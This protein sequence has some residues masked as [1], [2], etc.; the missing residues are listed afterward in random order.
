MFKTGEVFFIMDPSFIMGIL[1]GLGYISTMLVGEC[2]GSG[3]EM[4]GSAFMIFNWLTG[5]FEFYEKALLPIPDLLQLAYSI[6]FMGVCNS[7]SN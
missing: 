2:A 6:Y 3:A 1:T 7:D 5:D 4:A